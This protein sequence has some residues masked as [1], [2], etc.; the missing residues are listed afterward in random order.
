[1]MHDPWTDRLSEYVDGDL[2]PAERAACEA[3][4]GGC[5]ACRAIVADLRGLVAAARALPGLP[6]SQDLWPGISARTRD[7]VPLASAR[8]RA[9]P[10]WVRLAAAAALFLALGSGA[11]WLALS[12]RGGAAPVVATGPVAPAPAARPASATDRG[13]DAAVAE[14]EQVLAAGSARLDTQT[15]RVVAENLARID[16]AIVEAQ[17][18]LESDP[19]NVYVSRHLAGAE[20]RKLA[21]LRTAVRLVQSQS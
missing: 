12:A 4:L 6:P 16:S 7:V 3:H 17:R 11:T 9:L 18:A 1:M 20:K 10:S 8:P 19:S 13:T 15:V 5:A 14:L 21:L 2:A